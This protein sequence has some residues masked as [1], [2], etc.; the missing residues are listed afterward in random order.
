[1]DVQAVAGSGIDVGPPCGPEAGASAAPP[2]ST[3][4]MAL[5]AAEG[6]LVAAY[7]GNA[8]K[9]E[10]AAAT[11]PGQQQGTMRPATRKGAAEAVVSEDGDED[12]CPFGTDT[13]SEQK[14]GMD[15]Q[16]ISGL[17]AVEGW[18]SAESPSPGFAWGAVCSCGG[19]PLNVAQGG[20]C[21]SPT[22]P[23]EVASEVI[24]AALSIPPVSDDYPIA[25]L[26]RYTNPVRK[27]G[28][29]QSQAPSSCTWGS[30]CAGAPPGQTGT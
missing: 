8:A 2:P 25:G 3:T 29:V 30:C 4:D 11:E 20:G 7:R 19:L 24:N 28:V 23:Y 5:T 1:M 10:P 26:R 17:E 14:K 12:L 9:P 13:R 18:E 16:Q 6:A 15:T 27:G 21:S 22:I